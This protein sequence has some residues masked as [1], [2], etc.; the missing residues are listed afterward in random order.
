M[1]KQKKKKNSKAIAFAAQT[2]ISAVGFV[3]VSLLMKKT[4][5]KVYRDSVAK[6]EIDFDHMGPEIVKKEKDSADGM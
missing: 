1:E 4:L 5:A 6:E 3:V 2:A